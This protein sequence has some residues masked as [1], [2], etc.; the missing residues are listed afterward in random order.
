M[1]KRK[2]NETSILSQTITRQFW[3]ERVKAFVIIEFK[4]RNRPQRNKNTGEFIFYFLP[5][6]DQSCHSTDWKWFQSDLL[7]SGQSH[8]FVEIIFEM[9]VSFY[10]KDYSNEK[11][12]P[13][14]FF[15]FFSSCS[16]TQTHFRCSLLFNMIHSERLFPLQSIHMKDQ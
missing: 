5:F 14:S 7:V 11:H 4:D 9:T 16:L 15:S 2:L 3:Q 8:P 1:L 10:L 12:S 13:L 6:L